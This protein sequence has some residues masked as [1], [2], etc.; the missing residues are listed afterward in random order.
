MSLTML[1]IKPIALGTLPEDGFLPSPEKC[2]ELITQRTK[3]IVL[4]TPNNPVNSAFFITSFAQSS[5][6]CRRLG[7]YTLRLSWHPS[8]T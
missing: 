1:G 5:N 4:V 6:T 3:A 2:E 7:P 8:R